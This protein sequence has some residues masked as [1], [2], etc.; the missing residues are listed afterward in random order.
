MDI[1][2]ERGCVF[3]PSLFFVLELERKYDMAAATTN[4]ST[5][6]EVAAVLKI[7]G[8]TVRQWADQGKIPC[9][10]CSPRVRRYNIPAVLA[11]LRDAN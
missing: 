2:P 9:L 10:K 6:K 3:I 8:F 5:T 4:W 1:T 7:H 11:A